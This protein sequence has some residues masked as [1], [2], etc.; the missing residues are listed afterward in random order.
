MGGR[1]DRLNFEGMF[2]KFQQEV[3]D[4][5]LDLRNR[6]AL[7]SGLENLN[8]AN[9]RRYAQSVLADRYD[10][11]D[12]EVIRQFFDPR[13]H[14]ASH[15]ERIDRFE[16]DGFRPLVS[17]LE[18]KTTRP[19][20]RVVKIL[21]WLIDFEPRPYR[22]WLKAGEAATPIINGDETTAS[23]PPGISIGQGVGTS[24][25]GGNRQLLVQFGIPALLTIAVAAY[26]ITTSVDC[27]EKQCMYWAEDH[28]VAVCCETTRLPG[29]AIVAIRPY[30]LQ[31]FQKITRPDTLTADQAN[32]VWYS[33]I[34]NTVEFFTAPA[35]THPVYH[36][37]SIKP[38]TAHIIEKYARQGAAG[39]GN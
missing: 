20:E 31:H 12:D 4:L 23:A 32:K 30:E 33:K 17:F 10:R 22:E 15:E 37:R 7:P 9:L 19:D 16:L 36:D 3:L 5:Y 13:N 38:A 25:A 18:G 24:R 21:A 14:Y 11:K 1:L 29:S 8:R 34:D 2:E 35:A 26:F 39:D 28:Y 27:W 6:H